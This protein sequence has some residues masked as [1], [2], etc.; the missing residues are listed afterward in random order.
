VD[1]LTNDS[2]RAEYWAAKRTYDRGAFDRWETIAAC[3]A[4]M[5]ARGVRP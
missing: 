1:C 3:T 5:L 2:L 4:E